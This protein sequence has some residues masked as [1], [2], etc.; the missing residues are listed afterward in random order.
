MKH[1]S[2]HVLIVLDGFGYAAPAEYNAISSAATPT[3]DKLWHKYPHTLLKASGS[4]VGLPSGVIGNSEV[5][6]ET[7]GAGR[8]IKQPSLI[9]NEAIANGNLAHNEALLHAFSLI[10]QSTNRIHL[11]GLLSDADVHS[12]LHHAYAFIRLAHQAGIKEIFVHAFLDGRDVAP[13]SAAHY[14]TDL[15]KTLKE[16]GA[17]QLASISGRFYAMDRDHQEERTK[18]CFTMLTQGQAVTESW[19]SIIAD[20]YARGLT[21]EYIKPT[22][23]I[24]QGRIQ[25]HD[26]ILFWNYRPDRARQLTSLLL[27]SSLKPAAFIIPVSYGPTY[28]Q[29]TIVL[30]PHKPLKNTLKEVL[31]A[32]GETIVSIAETEKYAHVTYFFGGGREKLWQGEEQIMIPS[33]GTA[34]YDDTPWMSASAITTAVINHMV[35]HPADFY[36]INYA[37]ADMVGHTGNIPATIKAVECIDKQLEKLVELV[38]KEMNGTIYLTADHGNAEEMYDAKTGQPH[39]SHT[40]NPVPF[41]IVRRDLKNVE[42]PLALTKLSDVAPF[43]LKDMGLPVPYEMT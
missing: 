33:L 1:Q 19:E 2:P 21:D 20:F 8:I 35:T 28:D 4:A 16:I 25:P 43:I 26:G 7:L 3:F 18:A 27:E 32:Q 37:N 22:L 30:F 13:R 11:M 12:D 14:L 38:V 23:L 10:K 17:G 6:H 40:T 9:L 15:E 31:A 42:M 39:T 34:H 24:S 41:I 36:L 29:R 5:G